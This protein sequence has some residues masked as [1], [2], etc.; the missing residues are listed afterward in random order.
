[1][2]RLMQASAANAAP[3]VLLDQAYPSAELQPLQHSPAPGL[4][5]RHEH[6]EHHEHKERTDHRRRHEHKEH[7]EHRGP[8]R[9]QGHDRQKAHDR[10]DRHKGHDKRIRRDQPRGRQEHKTC[11]EVTWHDGHRD[12]STPSQTSSWVDKFIED[13]MASVLN[14]ASSAHVAEPQPLP[15]Q[16]DMQQLARPDPS[17]LQP[18][19]EVQTQA[20]HHEPA[21]HPEDVLPD[22]AGGQEAAP[23]GN[24]RRRE[25]TPPTGA[26]NDRDS[27]SGESSANR[28]G[29]SGPQSLAVA[30]T[31]TTASVYPRI[32]AGNRYILFCAYAGLLRFCMHAQKVCYCSDFSHSV[33][34][35]LS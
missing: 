17:S 28:A 30:V 25:P 6:R 34:K 33:S 11:D 14:P 20:A 22:V 26:G 10:H 5:Q 12:E 19:A 18:S 27:S 4:Q 24:K 15:V 29:P 9:H 8:H 31:R 7:H 1:M 13:A 35:S 21:R 16:Q 32:S 23:G 2:S 3:A